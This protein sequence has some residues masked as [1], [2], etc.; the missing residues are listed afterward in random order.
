MNDKEI[1]EYCHQRRWLNKEG[2]STLV[3]YLQGDIID[4]KPR[5]MTNKL[6]KYLLEAYA[7]WN[8]FDWRFLKEN[9]EDK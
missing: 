6:M 9:K 2:L 8:P 3:G 7:L 1:L 5:K 4:L